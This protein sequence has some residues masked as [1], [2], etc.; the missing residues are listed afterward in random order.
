MD[1]YKTYSLSSSTST[2]AVV[3]SA[4]KESSPNSSPASKEYRRRFMTELRYCKRCGNVGEHWIEKHITGGQWL[5]V[6][7]LLLLGII[8][9]VIY[10]IY[11][12]LT[13][14][15]K[16]LWVCPKCGARLQSV[17]LSSPIAQETMQ[18]SAQAISGGA[19]CSNCGKPVLP[20]MNFCAT[21][22]A[23]RVGSQRPS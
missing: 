4:L 13:G 12:G 17:P 19:F 3:T 9:G 1:A 11:L 18:K 6:V 8:P 10:L 7:F 2:S 14:G 16:A 22:G 20:T 21:C 15:D 5:T 23:A